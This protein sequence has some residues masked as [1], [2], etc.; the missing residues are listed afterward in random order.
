LGWRLA[1]PWGFALVSEPSPL[2][3][4]PRGG[5]GRAEPPF[6]HS[7]AGG[8]GWRVT[9]AWSRRRADLASLFAILGQTRP[10]AEPHRRLQASTSAARRSDWTT[11]RGPA[12]LSAP[13][14][15]QA[16]RP[17]PESPSR[18][19]GGGGPNL[20]PPSPREEGWGGGC[21]WRC[22]DQWPRGKRS[23]RLRTPSSPVL[24]G[25]DRA[26]HPPPE[27]PSREA[28]G[29][30][31][32]PSFL[33]EGGGPRCRVRWASLRGPAEGR[34]SSWAHKSRPAG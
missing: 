9:E 33:A 18:G 23:L 3:P 27:S 1:C 21:P 19:A 5:R 6:S 22:H 17:P 25:R 7:G 24:A 13:P 34:G 11:Q 32:A 12:A 16:R 30:G 20:P 31:E 4:L 8:S 10:P 2:I 15:P 29:G 26:S 14:E 28:G